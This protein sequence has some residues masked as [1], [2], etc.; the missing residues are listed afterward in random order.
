VEGDRGYGRD[1]VSIGATVGRFGPVG[2]DAVD[3]HLDELELVP[4]VLQGHL[5]HRVQR[6]LDVGQL[7]Q[8]NLGQV[9]N[10]AANDGLKKQ[11]LI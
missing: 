10:D 9:G 6:D 11:K 7:V 2:V 4:A 5:D 1:E 8:R 3:G